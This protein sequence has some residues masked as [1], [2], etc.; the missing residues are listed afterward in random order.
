LIYLIALLIFC[1]LYY[2]DESG[3]NWPVIKIKIIFKMINIIKKF[4]RRKTVKSLKQPI[5]FKGW[6]GER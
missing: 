2:F 1:D 3:N 4:F 6:K 5:R